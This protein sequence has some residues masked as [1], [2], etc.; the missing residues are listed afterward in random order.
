MRR[1]RLMKSI[2]TFIQRLNPGMLFDIAADKPRI[3]A[4]MGT[5]QCLRVDKVGKEPD[6]LQSKRGIEE[7]TTLMFQKSQSSHNNEKPFASPKD[8]RKRLADPKCSSHFTVDP[9]LMYTFEIYDHTIDFHHYQQHFGGFVKVDLANKLNGQPLTLTALMVP[10]G[11]DE[12]IKVGGN[13]YEGE[14]VVYD[15]QVW[16]QRL[17]EKIL[18]DGSLRS[19]GGTSSNGMMTRAK[20]IDES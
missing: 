14:E 16:H 1:S 19:I 12:K 17:I 9:S 20:R 7:N 13:P 2:Q 11:K 8:R 10:R 5:C 4:P 3:M 15:F 6:I 18:R